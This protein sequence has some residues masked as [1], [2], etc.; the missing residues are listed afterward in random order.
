MCIYIHL[1]TY[2]NSHVPNFIQ[3]IPVASQVC[4]HDC[5]YTCMRA[6]CFIFVHLHVH[7]IHTQNTVFVRQCTYT[8]SFSREYVLTYVWWQRVV[9]SLNL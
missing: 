6:C 7:N 5:A 2:T 8:Y 1:F 9:V 3:D 4:A